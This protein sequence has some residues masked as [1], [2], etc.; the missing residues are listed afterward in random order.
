MNDIW[1]TMKQVLLDNFFESG[2]GSITPETK[3]GEIPDWDSMEAVNLQILLHDTFHVDLPLELL[4]EYTTFSELIRFM[5][6]PDMISEAV[7]NFRE[8][9]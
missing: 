2:D 9:N 8:R 3:L 6:Q 1:Q 7:R 5:E 4:Q